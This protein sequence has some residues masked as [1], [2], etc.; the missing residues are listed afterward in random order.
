MTKHAK[1]ITPIRLQ[2]RFEV[3]SA[4]VDPPKSDSTKCE[5]VKMSA[6]PVW[7]GSDERAVRGTDGLKKMSAESVWRGSDKIAVCVVDGL[8]NCQCCGLRC[9]PSD[10]PNAYCLDCENMI[11]EALIDEAQFGSCT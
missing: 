1:N 3:L 7:C 11:D 8:K 6:E 2:N 10:V 5:C 4:E 9:I